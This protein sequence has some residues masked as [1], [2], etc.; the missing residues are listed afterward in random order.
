VT[1]PAN[2]ADSAGGDI[3]VVDDMFD[4]LALPSGI[5]GMRMRAWSVRLKA[6]PLAGAAAPAAVFKADGRHPVRA[7]AGTRDARAA[8][9][10]WPG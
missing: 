2:R 5:F 10:I 7:G 4:D 1:H 8:G 9:R 3:S 6:V